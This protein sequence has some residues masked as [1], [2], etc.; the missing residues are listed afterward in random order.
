[1]ILLFS[2]I[3]LG[4]ETPLSKMTSQQPSMETLI[5]LVNRLQDVFNCTGHESLDLPQIV[6]VGSQ[7]SGKS[8]VLENIVRRD[9]LPRGGGIVTRRPLILQL[10]HT[11]GAEEYAQFTHSST[12]KY[13]DFDLVR[14]EIEEETERVVGGSKAISREPIYL[15][16]YSPHVLTLTLVDLPGLTKIAMQDQPPDIDVRI[17]KLVLEYI[18]KPNAIILAVSPANQDIANS[19]ALKLAREVDPDGTYITTNIIVL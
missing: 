2:L 8:S 13:S 3:F 19:D 16:I 1:V 14:R 10:I 9:F 11:P 4:Y 17:R 15:R 5:P 12:K 7:S 6:V 18:A